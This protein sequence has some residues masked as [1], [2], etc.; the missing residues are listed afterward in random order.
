M[1]SFRVKYGATI[2]ERY[3][4]D[5]S[6]V[7]P[8]VAKGNIWVGVVG[9]IQFLGFLIFRDFALRILFLQATELLRA[10]VEI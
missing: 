9:N 5:T 2:S 10:E 8:F 3:V 6:E 7:I 4:M 1:H